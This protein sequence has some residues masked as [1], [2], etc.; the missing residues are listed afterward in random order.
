LQA[1]YRALTRAIASATLL[2]EEIL[3]RAERVLENAEARYASGDM[4]LAEL[5]PIRRD[6]TRA[7]LDYLEALNEVMQAWAGLSPYA[8]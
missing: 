1:S 2:R 3:P 5:L 4:S 6:W 8:R 7:R